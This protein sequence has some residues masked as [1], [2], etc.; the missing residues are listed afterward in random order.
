MNLSDCLHSNSGQ[1]ISCSS[2][3][4][5]LSFLNVNVFCRNR[6]TVIASARCGHYKE[7]M[8]EWIHHL[9]KSLAYLNNVSHHHIY[10][11]SFLLLFLFHIVL[12]LICLCDS[13]KV[14]VIEDVSWIS[15]I[16][17]MSSCETSELMIKMQAQIS[18]KINVWWGNVFT[19]LL[20]VL[21]FWS[22]LLAFY[23]MSSE[24]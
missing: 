5:R 12:Q 7:K 4:S 14:A 6:A 8:N 23:T 3:G 24:P 13:L 17:S 22:D 9:A 18:C 11:A 1:L 2:L 21:K 16:R 15:Y 10:Q 19:I 20:F